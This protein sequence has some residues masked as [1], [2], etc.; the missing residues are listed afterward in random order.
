MART[1]ISAG[2]I[3]AFLRTNPGPMYSEVSPQKVL[4][5][6]HDL[7]SV[8][9]AKP[10]EYGEFV[11]HLF[12]RGLTVEPVG[13]RYWLKLPGKDRAYAKLYENSPTRISG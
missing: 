11:D 2:S 1:K 6:A 10:V 8:T 4:Q 3:E 12:G 13:T 7:Y 5:D 9:C